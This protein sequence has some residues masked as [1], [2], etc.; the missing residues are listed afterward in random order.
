MKW[1]VFC[2]LSIDYQEKN[3]SEN[4]LTNLISVKKNSPAQS[5]NAVIDF[6]QAMSL[7]VNKGLI[8]LFLFSHNNGHSFKSIEDLLKLYGYKTYIINFPVQQIQEIPSHALM[9]SHDGFFH[10]MHKMGEG[11]FAVAYYGENIKDVDRLE[12][13][14]QDRFLICEK[15]Q[16][17]S[18]PGFLDFSNEKRLLSIVII[19]VALTF[20]IS[21]LSLDFFLALSLIGFFLSVIGLFQEHLKQ[22]AKNIVRAVCA[23]GK[24]FSCDKKEN[25]LNVAMPILGIFYFWSITNAYFWGLEI[26]RIIWFG[27]PAGLLV[28]LASLFVQIR[29]KKMC[30]LCLILIFIYLIQ[31]TLT[32]VGAGK[33]F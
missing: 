13:L 3:D 8:N 30:S 32:L 31:T 15:A 16:D 29:N 1:L 26:E 24:Y 17:S 10:F 25:R 21:M 6:C 27:L 20:L 12:G 5:T 18:L 7:K 28:I 14:F 2:I 4:S 22:F 9:L 19:G 23:E 11:D 33:F